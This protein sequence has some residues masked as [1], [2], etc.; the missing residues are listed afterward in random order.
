MNATLM[1]S[2]LLS[3]AAL[4]PMHRQ[5][6]TWSAASVNATI[7][8]FG[9]SVLAPNDLFRAEAVMDRA[10]NLVEVQWRYSAASDFL[11]PP[12][13]FL[14]QKFAVT[15]IPTAVEFLNPAH[16]VVAGTHGTETI[17][18]VWHLKIP[19]VTPTG[20]V[21]QT[22]KSARLVYKASQTNVPGIVRSLIHN[23][24]AT[25]SVFARFTGSHDLYEITWPAD[26]GTG[27]AAV[28]LSAAQ[29]PGLSASPYDE[30]FG[31]NH[32]TK[33]FVYILR[34]KDALHLHDAFVMLDT[35]RDG[36]IDSTAL[37]GFND[38]ESNEA[39]DAA[40]WIEYAGQAPVF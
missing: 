11:S 28:V 37:W 21:G 29:A 16:L 13:H 33:G 27:V 7:A 1:A 6:P 35:N 24:G 9:F 23:R 39:L 15:F 36:V 2:T 4:A 20:L 19:V 10:K 31:G 34:V 30:P 26:S 17:V 38:F 12:E 18:E 8:P 25:Q 40:K 3:C 22:K 5:Q 14:A 32:T